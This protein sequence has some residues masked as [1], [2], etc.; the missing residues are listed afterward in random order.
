[1]IVSRMALHPIL[2]EKRFREYLVV[3][4]FPEVQGLQTGLRVEIIQ[5]YIDTV[6]FRDIMERF[7]ITQV[8]TLRWLVRQCL[9]N[10]A[11]LFSVHRFHQD[12]KSQGHGIS[13]DTLHS[14]FGYLI[15]A[16]LIS[17][18]PLSTSSERKRNSNPRKIYPSDPGLIGAF[19]ISGRTNTGHS[20]ETVIV[21]EL[22]RR[23]AEIGYL[24][25]ASGYEVDF[26]AR[27]FDGTEELIQVCAD[28]SSDETREREIRALRDAA[29]EHRRA[30]K[31][32]LILDRQQALSLQLPDVIVQ[33]VY[34]WLLLNENE[35]GNTR[36]RRRM[37][38]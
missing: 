34:E 32:L 9:R 3:G 7:G 23:K 25:T 4:G 14:M 22:E 29:E 13:K 31:R 16:F 36:T 18:I 35:A 12:L 5:G 11:S 26:H 28:I 6:L 8:A 33:P 10:P 21:G 37:D 24:K 1:M 15:D 20:L 2:L 38:K 27:Y 30:V 17:S 19:D